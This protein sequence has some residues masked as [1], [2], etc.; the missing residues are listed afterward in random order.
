[1]AVTVR[2]LVTNDDGVYSPALRALADAAAELGE[3]R[4]IAPDVEHSSSGHAVSASRPLSYRPANLAGRDAFRVNG[5]PA[6]CV[7]LGIHL[8]RHVDVVLSGLNLGLNLGPGIWHSGTVAAAKQAAMLGVRGV[9]LSVPAEPDDIIGSLRPWLDRTLRVILHE[10][11]TPRL[12]NVNFPRRPQGLVWTRAAVE[13]YDGVIVPSRD[14]KGRD[15]YWF[16]FEAATG[17]ERG[18][19]RWAVEQHWVSLT[20][21]RLEP[22][23]ERLLGELISGHP[24]DT[25]RAVEVSPAASTIGEAAAVR[26]DESPG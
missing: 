8:W 10:A 2:I 20:P 17:A 22:A 13:R 24:L 25:Q 21:L 1:M 9:A 15:V 14:P 7:A 6:D 12:V 5:T 23:D 4:I 19:D 26:R 18:S 11:T 16:T 3:V